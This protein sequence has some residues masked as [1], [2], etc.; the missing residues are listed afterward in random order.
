MLV[1]VSAGFPFSQSLRVTSVTD[2]LGSRQKDHS[3]LSVT[4]PMNFWVWSFPDA[5]GI[6]ASCVWAFSTL[7]K[8][9]WMVHVLLVGTWP[10]RSCIIDSAV[11]NMPLPLLWSSVRPGIRPGV[12]WSQRWFEGHS[13]GF[14]KRSSSPLTH[15][16]A[17][18]GVAIGAGW[19]ICRMG[20]SAPFPS[21]LP[22]ITRCRSPHRS[23][24]SH[25]SE[26][27]SLL[28]A[29]D[30]IEPVPPVDMRSEFYSPYFIVPKK[31]GGLR[32]ILDLRVLNRALHK[33]PFKMLTQK[34]IFKVRPSP[35]L[36]C[37]DLSP[38][39]FT[40]VAEAALFPL[41]ER[42]VC[43]LNYLE[44]LLILAQS[45]KQL[46]AHRDLV[47]RHLSKLGLRVNW[48]KRKLVARLTQER[49][50]PHPT[51]LGFGIGAKNPT[52]CPIWA[53]AVSRIEVSLYENPAPDCIGLDQEAGGPAGIFGRRI[54]P[55][56]WAGW[57]QCNTCQAPARLCAQGSYHSFQGQG[58][59]PAR[60][61][62]RGARPSPS[63]ALS[64]TRTATVC[65]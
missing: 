27:L 51:L 30:A 11:S 26:D 61:A 59:E 55:W 39:V 62:P 28:L 44:Y 36:V 54:V 64:C 2:E 21:M 1:H 57:L 33:L 50:Y 19:D 35:R 53:F 25:S 46:C 20:Y 40:K 58:S 10:S 34:H 38:P 14:T 47:V 7:R 16:S 18:S 42:G 29:K 48:E 13:E 24:G 45:R 32:P 23:A 3:T 12:R 6:A 49:A 41:R 63:F 17:A 9:S 37:S 4:K 31:S 43:I 8:L 52:N 15:R 56:V 22:L 65:G 60:A 5:S